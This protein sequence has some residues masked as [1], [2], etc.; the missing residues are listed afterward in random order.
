MREFLM[1]MVLLC[2]LAVPP[3]ILQEQ[4][5]PQ[6]Q[7]EQSDLFQIDASLHNLEKMQEQDLRIASKAIHRPAIDVPKGMN[8]V[9]Y[10]HIRK[11][12]KEKMNDQRRKLRRRTIDNRVLNWDLSFGL[13]HI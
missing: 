12:V 4:E 6:E 11:A 2:Y 10:K 9:P 1:L 7:V 5:P 13:S 8:T 3:L